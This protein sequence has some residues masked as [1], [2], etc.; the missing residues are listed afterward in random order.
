MKIALWAMGL[1]PNCKGIEALLRNAHNSLAEAL[2][3]NAHK[4]KSSCYIK[5]F[6]PIHITIELEP[7]AL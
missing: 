4:L 1:S 5:A 7:H 6:V 2:L 3:R